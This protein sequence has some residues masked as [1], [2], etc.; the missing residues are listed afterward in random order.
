MRKS[1]K[2]KIKGK[3]KHIQIKSMIREINIDPRN[4]NVEEFRQHPD[5]RF[6]EVSNTAKVKKGTSKIIPYVDSKNQMRVLFKKERHGKIFVKRLDE[7]VY[8]TFN[9]D[10]DKNKPIKHIDGNPHNCKLYNLIQ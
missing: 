2:S 5:Y 1:L 6:I 3:I 4:C 10:Y 9:K 7:L 8:E